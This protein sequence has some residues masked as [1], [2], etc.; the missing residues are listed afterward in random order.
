ML[1]LRKCVAIVE[2]EPEL[3]EIYSDSLKQF[4]E[5]RTFNSAEQALDAFD[6]QFSAD[7]CVSDYM[8]PGINGLAFVDEI[9]KRHIQCPIILISGFAGV[10]QTKGALNRGL[11]GF[12]EK[13]F[14]LIELQAMVT[15]AADFCILKDIDERLLARYYLLT[16]SLTELIDRHTGKQSPKENTVINSHFLPRKSILEISPRLQ[17]IKEDGNL[18]KTIEKIRLEIEILSSQR[19]SIIES[20]HLNPTPTR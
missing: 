11:L 5:V 18:E 14:D 9:R 17:T 20:T 10:D 12:I 2:D 16:E 13:P 4:F 1:N 6:D 8:M 15:K 7:I 19:H 3:A